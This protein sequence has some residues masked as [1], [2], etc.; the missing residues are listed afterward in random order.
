MFGAIIPIAVVISVL[1]F[2]F[3]LLLLDIFTND[4]LS[5]IGIMLTLFYVYKG[6]VAYALW[7]EKDWAIKVAKIDAILSIILCC[8]ATVYNF[9]VPQDNGSRRLNF[10]I[11][12]I[13]IIPYLN[14]M[15]KIQSAWE[16]FDKS[17][18]EK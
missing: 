16:N 3:Q 9:V 13:I 15:N 18:T 4:P 8:F 5:P 12:L 1:K 2:K 10:A 7:T 11:E 6:V 14:K 17:H